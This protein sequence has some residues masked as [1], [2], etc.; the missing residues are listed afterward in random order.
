VGGRAF[1]EQAGRLP[2][3]VESAATEPPPHNSGYSLAE[4]TE[5]VCRFGWDCGTAQR[6]VACESRWDPGAVSWAGSYGLW[7]IYAA[8]W[9][10]FFADFW[11]NWAD[12]V[13]NTEMAWEIYE[14]AG[15]SFSPWNCW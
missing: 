6:I 7:Q 5:I 10:P 4:L 12:P 1:D 13:R 8:T 3:D 2:V 15:F 14:R 9:A 11:E